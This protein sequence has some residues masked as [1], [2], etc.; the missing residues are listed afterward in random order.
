[1]EKIVIKTIN[2]LM[3]K[4]MREV[5]EVSLIEKAVIV[6]LLVIPVPFIFEGYIIVKTIVRNR[7]II[8]A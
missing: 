4:L 5:K 8:R 7:K 2:K 1:M 6:G 3:S